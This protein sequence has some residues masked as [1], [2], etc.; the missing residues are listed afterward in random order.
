VAQLRADAARVREELER[1]GEEGI[2][3]FDRSLLK[4]VR[5]VQ[6]PNED[7]PM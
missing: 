6:S 5:V 2:A 4:P 3:Q 1:V 7:R